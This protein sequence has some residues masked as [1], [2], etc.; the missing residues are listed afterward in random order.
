MSI[1][2]SVSLYA[3]IPV[4]VA[5]SLSVSISVCIYIITRTYQL[6]CAN[7]TELHESLLGAHSQEI[8]ILNFKE[9]CLSEYQVKKKRH[10]ILVH[11]TVALN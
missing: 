4:S 6:R 8:F 7:G 2:V 11:I 10:R 3:S 5:V 1:G 9:N